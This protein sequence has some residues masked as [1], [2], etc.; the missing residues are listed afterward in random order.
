MY[1]TNTN[2]LQHEPKRSGRS[3]ATVKTKPQPYRPEYKPNPPI[4]N[5]LSTSPVPVDSQD[6]SIIKSLSLHCTWL[7][8]GIDKKK[9]AIYKLTA[10]PIRSVPSQLFDKRIKK[11][12][13]T[14]LESLS[15]FPIRFNQFCSLNST[16]NFKAITPSMKWN[17]VLPY[18]V[19][20]LDL[21]FKEHWHPC[22]KEHGTQLANKFEHN[23]AT[24]DTILILSIK[25]AKHKH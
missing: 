11:H 16:H 8:I 12:Q 14:E 4:L 18:M 24:T 19:A 22:S 5:S 6:T 2:V 25:T 20:N 9:A 3:L 23:I 21:M 10:E 13:Y 1:F 15:S 17:L 7:H